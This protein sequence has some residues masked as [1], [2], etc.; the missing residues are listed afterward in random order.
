MDATGNPTRPRM[1]LRG[2]T[3]VTCDDDNQIL[4]GDI[5]IRDGL[6]EQVVPSAPRL[7]GEE[8]I[9]LTG[10]IVMPA[11]IQ[12]HVH[13]CQTLWRNLADDMSLMTWL[14]HRTWPFE[15][16]MTREM[17][18]ASV[19]LS[20]A[21]LLL[22]GTLTI[23]DFGLLH[24]A[25]AIPAAAAGT[26]LRGVWASILVD[27]LDPSSGL[28]PQEP[29]AA[30]RDAVETAQA[31][32][33]LDSVAGYAMSPRF[34]PS[35][36]RELLTL[37]AQTSRQTGIPIHTHCSENDEE[38]DLSVAR[39]G[40]RPLALFD[41]LGILGPDT[42][43]AHCV[44]VTDD[45]I[46]LLAATETKVLHCP[47]TN[48]KLGSGIAP[49]PRMLQAGV[50]VS[51]GADGAPA[52][53]NLDM[54]V[55]MRAAS[56]IQKALHGPLAMPAWQVIRM[57]TV[58]GAHALGLDKQTGSL[59]PGRRADILVLNP[60]LP[61]STGFDDPCKA[62]VYSMGRDNVLH[63]LSAGRFVVKDHR[64]VG[65]DSDEVCETA[66][67]AMDLLRRTARDYN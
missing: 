56:L 7:G 16:A 51:I 21:E 65:L 33:G 44:K 50:Q 11:F 29:E 8:S 66:I 6:I 47:S 34:A 1:V 23:N 39:F 20:A 15:D 12:T 38:N 22:S 3:V 31:V 40:M 30:V 60:R 19:R 13:T 58:N 36:S 49:I 52:N 54:F 48:M 62:I 2:A 53:N 32:R 26:G 17:I 24:D 10:L 14:R 55:E 35:C 43:L 59:T 67:S 4:T 5:V 9:D 18:R 63:L 41:E 42:R 25:D 37:V 28:T 46:A 61:H 64:C 27:T 45:E 57:A